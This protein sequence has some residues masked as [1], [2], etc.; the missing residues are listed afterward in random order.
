MEVEERFCMRSG[1][2][3]RNSGAAALRLFGC[4]S[5]LRQEKDELSPL[6]VWFVVASL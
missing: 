5:G 3:R 4:V 1:G 6:W 2:L